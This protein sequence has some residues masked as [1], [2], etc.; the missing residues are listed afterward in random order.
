MDFKW[1]VQADEEVDFDGVVWLIG[2]GVLVV[3]VAV[4]AR[5]RVVAHRHWADGL[6][7]FVVLFDQI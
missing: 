3:W 6:W 4:N 5:V 2:H 7:W 1:F